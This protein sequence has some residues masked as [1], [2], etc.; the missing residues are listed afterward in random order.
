LPLPV[1][2]ADLAAADVSEDCDVVTYCQAGIRGA[3]VAFVLTLLGWD[4]V[5][6]CDGSMLEWANRDDTPLEVG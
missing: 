6:L 5:R 4:S 3:F 1:F 2:T